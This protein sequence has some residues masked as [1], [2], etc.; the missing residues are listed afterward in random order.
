MKENIDKI[1]KEK[2]QIDKKVPYSYE[3]YCRRFKTLKKD[4]K[5]IFK[6]LLLLIFLVVI[7]ILVYFLVSDKKEVP[8]K[9]NK[10]I[11]IVNEEE[12][13]S[14]LKEVWDKG[15]KL[16]LNE[17]KLDGNNLNIKMALD[18]KNLDKALI[19]ENENTFE[20]STK[21][22]FEIFIGD[23]K[24]KTFSPTIQSV[25]LD[26][27]TEITVKAEVP[28]NEI[29]EPIKLN[30]ICD[31]LDII[32][33]STKTNS[34]SGDW[35]FSYNINDIKDIEK[36]K[37]LKV[38]KS[39]SL[40]NENF[41]VKLDVENIIIKD[42]TIDVSYIYE[43]KSKRRTNNKYSLE[44][45]ILNSFGVEIVNLTNKLND[46]EQV[47]RITS[48][49]I[50]KETEKITLVPRITKNTFFSNSKVIVDGVPIEIELKDLINE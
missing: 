36:G 39:S 6:R 41:N 7:S 40:I 13:T 26:K 15:I 33:S 2:E 31:K 24:M 18:Y 48:L 21:G 17:V 43:E 49:K 32:Y 45:K 30:Y 3:E 12:K 1:K 37:V 38:N 34:I 23:K 4:N 46:N 25:F 9:A 5:K 8:N 35:N 16:E 10:D 47:K 20:I 11:L 44:V 27:E 29:K 22:H 50:D 14:V 19:D 42:G 28:V